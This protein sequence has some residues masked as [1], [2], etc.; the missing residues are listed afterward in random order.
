MPAAFLYKFSRD[1]KS[2][3]CVVLAFLM[4]AKKEVCRASEL[5]HILLEM[6]IGM[7]ND[8]DT[9]GFILASVAILSTL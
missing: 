1:S 3:L 5:L 6:L 7:R 9:I 4:T 2:F 8:M